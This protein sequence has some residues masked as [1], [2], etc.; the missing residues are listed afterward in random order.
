MAGGDL[1]IAL[2]GN[3]VRNFDD[4]IKYLINNKS[5]GDVIVITVLRGEEEVDFSVTLGKRP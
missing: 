3:P 4:L 5:P 1:I 2:D